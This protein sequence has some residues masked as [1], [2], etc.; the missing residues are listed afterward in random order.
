[1][2]EELTSATLAEQPSGNQAN[3]SML[4]NEGS[5]VP[6]CSEVYRAGFSSLAAGSV[7]S[8]RHPIYQDTGLLL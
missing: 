8:M 7:A 6:A 1:M 4:A 2:S 3:N 5:D